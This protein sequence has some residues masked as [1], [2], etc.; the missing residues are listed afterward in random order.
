MSVYGTLINKM[1]CVMNLC[2]DR[3]KNFNSGPDFLK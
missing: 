3:V 2:K 1:F